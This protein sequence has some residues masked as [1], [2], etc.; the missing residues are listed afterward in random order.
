MLVEVRVKVWPRAW[1]KNKREKK[2][3]YFL[4]TIFWE[5]Y[6]VKWFYEGEKVHCP[7]S[8]GLNVFIIVAFNQY[9]I[10]QKYF[11]TY[12]LLAP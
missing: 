12:W 10:T 1:K 2:D 4:I 5:S 6:H 8:S 7:G 9:S 3:L 11:S